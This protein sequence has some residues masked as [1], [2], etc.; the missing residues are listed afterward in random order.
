VLEASD[1]LVYKLERVLG[2]K[3]LHTDKPARRQPNRRD[4]YTVHDQA[5]QRLAKHSEHITARSGVFLLGARPKAGT[6]LGTP[7][8]TR[9][10]HGRAEADNG[11]WKRI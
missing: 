1:C 4:I 11:L 3:L 10:S 8:A 9:L 7:T 2:V 6:T 5:Q